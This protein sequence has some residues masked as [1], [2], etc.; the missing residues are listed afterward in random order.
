MPTKA[1]KACT[2][3]L[4]LMWLWSSRAEF[5]GLWQTS[6]GGEG[7]VKWQWSERTFCCIHEGIHDRPQRSQWH[8]PSTCPSGPRNEEWRP[9]LLSYNHWSVIW[10]T[11]IEPPG[12]NTQGIVILVGYLFWYQKMRTFWIWLIPLNLMN[13]SSIHVSANVRILFFMVKYNS[14]IAHFL[15]YSSVGRY[16]GQPHNLII[17]NVQR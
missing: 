9:L 15:N 14:T 10:P 2:K 17:V 7:E 3:W 5:G 4:K 13:P 12:R 16:L 11:P 6:P 1:G 8:R